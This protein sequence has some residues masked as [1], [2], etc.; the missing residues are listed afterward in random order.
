M[1]R[2]T[3]LFILFFDL[4]LISYSQVDDAGLWL[5]IN[6][7]KKINKKWSVNIS[8]GFRYNENI[9][10]L[11]SF[12]TD[13]GATY[14][15]NKTIRLSGNYRYAYKRLLDNTYSQRHRFY[16]DINI[17]SKLYF[18]QIIYRIRIQNQ[19]KEFAQLSEE[20]VL[21]YYLR[22]K[23]SL[24][25][26]IN[27]NWNYYISFENYTP[28]FNEILFTDNIR[29]TVG[30][31]YSINKSSSFEISYIIQKEY[32]VKNPYTYYVL[33]LSYNYRL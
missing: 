6:I 33:G 16:A 2:R 11:G 29:Y 24:I 21:K 23:L 19:F 31:E 18:L 25:Y 22:N 28:L 5:S 4:F 32:N 27:K 26:P 15:I 13:I 3:L 20:N 10:E 17:R 12:F 8:Q 7:N 1:I 9:T 14:K 30:T